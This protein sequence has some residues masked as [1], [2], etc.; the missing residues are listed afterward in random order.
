MFFVKIKTSTLPLLVKYVLN[1]FRELSNEIMHEV[2]SKGASELSEMKILDFH[3]YLIKT[4][5][6]LK[7]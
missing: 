7:F 3:V 2:L 1:H 6:F 4:D 5:F